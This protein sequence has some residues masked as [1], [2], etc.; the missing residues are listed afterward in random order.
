MLPEETNVNQESL[1]E[2]VNQEVVNPE[3]VESGS[4]PE[5]QAQESQEAQ[6]PTAEQGVTQEPQ[7][8]QRVPFDRF[9]AVNDENKW[10][11]EQLSVTM[12]QR[13]VHQP[14]Q[15]TDPYAGMDPA[16]EK[17]YRDLD[18]RVEKRAQDIIDK[19]IAPQINAGLKEVAAIKT[20]Q[21]FKEHPDV[22][23]GS[24]EEAQISAKVRAGY[25]TD[26]AYWS[27]MG[28][29]GIQSAVN[30]VKKQT[31]QKFQQKRQANVEAS[32]GVPNSSLPTGKSERELIGEA[33]EGSP[34][35]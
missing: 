12:A 10:L 32:P 21:F 15:Q 24:V 22:K 34:W 13:Q 23:P 11:R 5:E 33:L 14:Q 4:S 29:R 31:Q 27:V 19:R 30:K 20:M 8:E 6:A 2:D 1:P 25:S 28:P 9:K 35:L 26:D 17:F 16:T 18:S 3:D 7:Q